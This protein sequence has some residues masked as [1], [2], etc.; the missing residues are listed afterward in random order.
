MADKSF[1]GRRLISFLM[2]T[3]LMAFIARVILIKISAWSAGIYYESAEIAHFIITGH[4]YSWDWNGLVPL[5][6][7]AILP[8]IYTYFTAFFLYLNQ[9]PARLFY[10]TQAAINALGIIPS[11][12]LGKQLA[13]DKAGIFAAVT[14]AFFPEFAFTSAKPA[15]ESLLMPF[16]VSIFYLF[17]KFKRKLSL[18]GRVSAFFWLGAL[19]G[20]AA[21]IKTTAA[22]I[23][24]AGFASL[25]ISKPII[26][27]RVLAGFLLGLGFL[28]AIAPWSIR[29]TAVM[30]KPVLLNTMYGYNLWR[31]NHP[32]STGTSRLDK[33]K[34]SEA[35]LDPEYQKYLELNYPKTEIEI[36]QFFLD[37]A[38]KFIKA[39]PIRYIKLTLKR[40]LYYLTFDPTHPLSSN[41]AYIA[42]YIFAVIF[43]VWGARILL[44]AGK[45]DY[46]FLYTGL[47]FIAF[48]TPIIVLPRYRLIFTWLL[49]ALSSV[50][51]TRLLTRSSIFTNLINRYLRL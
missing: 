21:L 26:K 2:L 45:F 8:P 42:G 20:F 49:V 30:G 32:W 16:V 23:V 31:G 24:P 22:F 5:Q 18:N 15:A 48:Y 35:N 13:G 37:E 36:D 44:K 34:T 7:T 17:L 41:I 50:S 40:V 6:P 33:T 43:G 19:I 3:Y 28:A 46:I 38:K 47:I 14:Y 10:I 4:G 29:N 39:D 12:F 25:V 1:P 9:N 51:L 27:K 11:Y